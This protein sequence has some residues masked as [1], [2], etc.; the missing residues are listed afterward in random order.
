MPL[1][2]KDIEHFVYNW[3]ARHKLDVQADNLPLLADVDS[4][5]DA[6]LEALKMPILD[7]H[8]SSE[9]CLQQVANSM[10]RACL[11]QLMD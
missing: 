11:L 10:V 3:T 6:L 9:R 7:E 5:A 8:G 4:F 2:S 1:L